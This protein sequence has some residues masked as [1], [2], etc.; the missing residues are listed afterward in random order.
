MF[1]FYFSILCYQVPT[2]EGIFPPLGPVSGGTEL[3]IKGKNL[4][5]G[6]NLAVFVGAT[7]CSVQRWHYTLT[8][9]YKA[10]IDC[11]YSNQVF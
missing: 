9:I 7:E 10:T 1:V 11:T 6:S 3:L 5:I 8:Q 4:D 2:V